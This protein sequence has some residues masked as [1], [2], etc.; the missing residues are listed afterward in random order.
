M[1]YRTITRTY[2]HPCDRKII[3][4]DDYDLA[5]IAR[6]VEAINPRARVHVGRGK[7]DFPRASE[8]R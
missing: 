2:D 3:I 7:G 8:R 1:T 6:R 4:R 5:R